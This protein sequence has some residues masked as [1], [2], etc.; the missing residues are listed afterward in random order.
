LNFRQLQIFHA[1]MRT[2]SVTGAARLLHISQPAVSKA[3]RQLKLETGIPLFNH[4][5]GRLYPSA[6]AEALDIRAQEIIGRFDCL[7]YFVTE[8]RDLHAGRL[9]IAT[10]STL[11]TTII[12]G[13][14]SKFHRDHAKVQVEISALPSQQVVELVRE[15]KVDLAFFHTL[16]EVT[17]V[18]SEEICG[19]ELVCLIRKDS[20]LAEK[21]IITPVDLVNE[22]IVT[23][24]F[25]TS[26]GWIIKETFRQQQ[27]QV[28]ETLFVNQTSTAIAMVSAGVGVG[29][30]D[31]FPLFGKSTLD[32]LVRPFSPSISLVA[33]VA[34]PAMQ[35]ES[36]LARKF[37]ML[38]KEFCRDHQASSPF[39]IHIL[40]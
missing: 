26:I 25:D 21:E 9:H 13:I 17:K 28:A 38:L 6:E 19:S 3:L 18:D 2:G 5:N 31:P 1:V 10:L 37:S 14:I 4:A 39:P 35:P 27:V 8:L 16:R 7:D 36:L 20:A 40:P 30:I 32:F 11:A 22:T 15:G 34:F 33:R 12:P 29:L 23:F 24:N